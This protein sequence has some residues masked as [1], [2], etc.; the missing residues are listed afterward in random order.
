MATRSSVLGLSRL[1]TFH[2]ILVI[3]CRW[4]VA[5]NVT[6]LSRDP[7]DVGPHIKWTAPS[8]HETKST[9]QRACGEDAASGK[10]P[11]MLR[12]GRLSS[13]CPAPL[14]VAMRSPLPFPCVPDRPYKILLVQVGT[15]SFSHPSRLACPFYLFRESR[16]LSCARPVFSRY[17]ELP[18]RHTRAPCVT[19]SY[20]CNGEH[21]EATHPKP[22]A[23]PLPP[24]IPVSGPYREWPPR[25]RRPE[26]RYQ[27]LW[28]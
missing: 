16:A 26:R 9:L 19:S 20:G 4:P 18:R 3:L 12:L 2:N 25:R 22:H 5:A 8:E 27:I 17:F 11:P 14:R 13:P 15:L 6:A 10:A 21:D 28:I 1:Y 24:G 23:V 7:S